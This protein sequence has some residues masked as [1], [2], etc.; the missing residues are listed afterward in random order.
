MA[1][2]TGA[3]VVETVRVMA[4]T[5]IDTAIDKNGFQGLGIGLPPLSWHDS[6]TASGNRKNQ[7]KSVIVNFW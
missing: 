5:L 2:N 6:S 1:R 7:N 3:V 4:I